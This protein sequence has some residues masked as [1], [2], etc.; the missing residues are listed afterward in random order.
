[1]TLAPPLSQQVRET[2]TWVPMKSTQT[3]AMLAHRDLEGSASDFGFTG[4][5]DDSPYDDDGGEEPG[6]DFSGSG[7]GGEGP[8]PPAFKQMSLGNP[9]LCLHSNQRA[10]PGRVGSAGEGEKGFLAWTAPRPPSC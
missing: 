9:H 2:E 8:P 4:D 1:M 6:D 5:E 10:G 7:D 3:A